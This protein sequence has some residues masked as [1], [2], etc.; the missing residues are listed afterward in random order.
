MY[1]VEKRIIAEL[2]RI[3]AVSSLWLQL[4]RLHISE[5][6]HRRRSRV[7]RSRLTVCPP[8]LRC[9]A[10]R[11]RLRDNWHAARLS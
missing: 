1:S 5:A 2:D 4:A 6:R 9:T 11:R 7:D 10:R 3:Q 8:I